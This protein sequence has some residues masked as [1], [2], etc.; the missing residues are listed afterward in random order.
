MPS[1]LITAALLAA[2]VVTLGA[3][4]AAPNAPPAYDAAAVADSGRPAA[5]VARDPERKPADMLVFAGV[6]PG[7]TVAELLPGGGYFTRLFSKAVGPSG[8][9]YAIVPKSQA[10]G[11]K[12]PPVQAIAAD[13]AYANVQVVA[14]DL[15]DLALPQPVDLVW[16]SQ[17]Y[18]DLHLAKMHLDVAAVDRAI[19]RALKPG[20]VF[21]VEDHAAAA[22]SGLDV[23]DRLHRINPEIV[24]RE[25]EAAGFRFEGESRVLRNP[26]DDH[27]TPVFD[28]SIRGRTDQFVYRFRK[29][30]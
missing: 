12:P 29:P 13:P 23:P 3:A 27:L 11:A 20:G 24:K 15:A 7:E 9:V 6:R 18:H 25:V 10:N 1:N 16:T 17:N 2:S 30:R 5:D 26:A 8:R 21:I 22:G 14:A 4:R 28:P 19:F